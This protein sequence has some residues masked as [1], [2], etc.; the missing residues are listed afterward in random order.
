MPLDGPI[1]AF[2]EAAC[3][4]R[5]G[6]HG[7]GTLEEANAILARDPLV[8]SS[9][10][11]TAAILG[12]EAGVRAFLVR[13]SANANA[14][15][16]PHQWD[17]LTHLCFSRYLRLD[18]SRGEAFVRTARALLEAGASAKTGWIEMIDHP[19]P[20]PT[21]ESAIYGAAGIARHPELT[22][23]LLAYGADP[24]DEET[25]YHAPEGYDNTVMQIL[26][27]SGKLNATSLTTMLVRKADWHDEAGLKMVLEHGA[28]PNAVTRWGYTALQHALRRDNSIQAIELLLD[29]GAD[30][31]SAAAMAARRGRGDVLLVFEQRGRLALGAGDRL[32][33]DCAK[34]DCQAVYEPELV[35]EVIAEGGTLLAQFAGNGN[36][37]GMRCLLGLGVN[38]DALYEAGDPFFDIAKDSTALH[39]AAWRGRHATVQLLIERG[40]A[41][42]V[43]DGKGRTA[44][45]LAVK[46]CVDSYWKARRSTDSIAALLQAGARI[47]GIEIPTGYDTAD[48][49]LRRH[50]H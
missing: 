16:G 41:V 31:Q 18:P 10:I 14:Q 9:S 30:A 4:P 35:A 37:E 13:D 42:N 26:L 24:N 23:L 47:D 50:R 34:G 49:L 6:W 44:L 45:Q 17:A 25:P 22:R 2:I 7:S 43:V 8:A 15:G 1:A 46:A 19:N 11:H 12:D 5:N 32:I 27:E 39:V 48:E 29:H 38:V 36:V 28:D 21:F 40:A 33:A 3:V 20:R